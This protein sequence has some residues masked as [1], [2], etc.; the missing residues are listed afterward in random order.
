LWWKE[1]CYSTSIK[2]GYRGLPNGLL[3]VIIANDYN[4]FVPYSFPAS[5]DYFLR[6]THRLLT[7]DENKKIKISEVLKQIQTSNKILKTIFPEPKLETGRISLLNFV[8][9]LVWGKYTLEQF[10]ECV[11]IVENTETTLSDIT[12]WLFH[13]FQSLKIITSK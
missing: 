10:Q 8:E 3:Q 2:Q 6:E 9:G 1:A 7:K 4:A 12:V 13:D 11:G 5:I